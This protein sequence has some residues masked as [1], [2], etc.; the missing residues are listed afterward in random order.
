MNN[1]ALRQLITEQSPEGFWREL[2][3]RQE[4]LYREAYSYSNHG[5]LWDKHEALVVFPIVRRAVFESAT[6]SAAQNNGMKAYNLFHTGDT[7]PYVLV[8]AKKLLITC[9]HVAAPDYFVRQAESRK[10]NAAVNKWLDYYMR[11]ELML[12]PLP[13]LRQSG[14]INLYILHGQQPAD[15]DRTTFTSFLQVA[16]PDA[17]LTTYRKNFP[18]SE[19]LQI[20]AQKAKDDAISGLR[21]ADRAMPRIKDGNQ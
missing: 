2:S 20:Y 13:D 4:A 5:T 21:I 10:Q 19:L 7:Y 3:T 8:K 11:N 16:I 9:H 6:R 15:A 18:V 14:K 12:H 17:D 1:D